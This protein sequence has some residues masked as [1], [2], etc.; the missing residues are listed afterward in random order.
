MEAARS[1]LEAGG[2]TDPSAALEAALPNADIQVKRWGLKYFGSNWSRYQTVL[3]ANIKTED[4]TVKCRLAMPET[5][6]GAPT[7]QELRANDGA[8]LQRQLDGLISACLAKVK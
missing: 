2:V 7:L 5:P 6:V 4:E 8:V 1:L 3:D